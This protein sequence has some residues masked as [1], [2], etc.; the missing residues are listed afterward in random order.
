MLK[1][2]LRVFGKSVVDYD[3]L[4]TILCDCESVINNRPLTYIHDDPSEL[5]LLTPAT[6][7]YGEGSNSNETPD[8]DLVNR[9]SMLKR[10]KFLQ[11]LREDLKQR[12]RN[13]YLAQL[14][15]KG[16]RRNG[17]INIGNIVLIGHGQDNS[18]RIEPLGI[19]LELYPG[20]DSIPSVARLR[21][22]REEKIRPF[23]GLYPLELSAKNDGDV[24]EK[25]SMKIN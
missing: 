14:V 16:I 13:E 2:L 8:L 11:K 15:H 4:T 22:S 19:V 12:F 25:S 5:V 1:T 10:V 6:F 23:Q 21:T 7:I 24:L 20:K 3:E 18:R 9:T 17:V